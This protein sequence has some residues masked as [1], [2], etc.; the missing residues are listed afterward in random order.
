MYVMHRAFRSK[1]KNDK[2]MQ[3]ENEKL[4]TGTK[5][6]ISTQKSN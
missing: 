2:L 4:K 6:L 3:V 5:V 1:N